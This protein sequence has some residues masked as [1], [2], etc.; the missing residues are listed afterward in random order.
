MTT[1]VDNSTGAEKSLAELIL[2]FLAELFGWIKSGMSNFHI[3]L[4]SI[5]R[6]DGRSATGAI[7]YRAGEKILDSRTGNEF[8][9]TKKKGVEHSQIFFPNN[10]KNSRPDLYDRSKLWNEIEKSEKKS[11]ALVAH[12]LEFSIPH[13]LNAKQRKAM[14]DEFCKELAERHGVVV[15]ASIHAPHGKNADKRNYHAH[16][17]FSTRRFENGEFGQKAREFNKLPHAKSEIKKELEKGREDFSLRLDGEKNAA[18]LWR[19]V[20]EKIGNKFLVEAGFDPSLDRRSYLERG[21][22]KQPTIHEGAGRQMAKRGLQSDRYEENQQIIKRNEKLSELETEINASSAL[23]S[24]LDVEYDEL[25]AKQGHIQQQFFKDAEMQKRADRI[26]DMCLNPENFPDSSLCCELVDHSHYLNSDREHMRQDAKDAI[27]EITLDIVND[28]FGL[29]DASNTE[30]HE[31]QAFDEY[32]RNKMNYSK[33]EM[34]IKH[35]YKQH[36]QAEPKQKQIKQDAS[37]DYSPDM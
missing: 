23:L 36:E 8:D 27:A 35:S 32:L 25:S 31:L 11:N 1:E 6:A 33:D 12:E 17:M 9:Y 19:A 20:Y 15:D 16:V 13:E 34:P 14:V 37:N 30:M 4:K 2:E 5:G 21:I 24:R 10:E 29:V 26:L 28:E 7:A 18:T 3:H 22:D